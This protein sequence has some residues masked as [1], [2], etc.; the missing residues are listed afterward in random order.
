MQFFEKKIKFDF[1]VTLVFFCRLLVI[2]GMCC[3]LATNAIALT[4]SLRLVKQPRWPKT[5]LMMMEQRP[6]RRFEVPKVGCPLRKVG[7]WEVALGEGGVTSTSVMHLL[8]EEG[9][10]KKQDNNVLSNVKRNHTLNDII[11]VR[12]NQHNFWTR[13]IE[14]ILLP[15]TLVP[16]ATNAIALTPS[17]RLMKQPRCPAISP[18]I[19]VQAPMK[20]IETTNVM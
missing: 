10:G 9:K 15:G 16:K 17:L 20:R 19:A 18:I 13:S 4:P 14:D 1:L 12:N 11:R 2:S 7:R 8:V 3:L 6:I 5:S